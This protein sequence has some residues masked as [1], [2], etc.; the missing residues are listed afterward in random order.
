[1]SASIMAQKGPGPMP[2]ISNT[3]IP[4]NGPIA[5]PLLDL[6]FCLLKVI[7]DNQKKPGSTEVDGSHRMKAG[8]F[9]Q[10]RTSPPIN[11]RLKDRKKLK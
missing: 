1:M 4:F 9:R 11:V 3:R 10:V 5:R 2:A 6:R 8:M 7:Q